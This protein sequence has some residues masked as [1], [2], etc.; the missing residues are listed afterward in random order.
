MGVTE[1]AGGPLEVTTAT[2]TEDEGGFKC[3]GAV[4][5]TRFRI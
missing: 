4:E 1:K 2:Q 3:V 5:V